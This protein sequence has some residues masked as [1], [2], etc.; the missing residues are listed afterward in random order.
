MVKCCVF[1]E[2]WTELL[3]NIYM[4][5]GIKGLISWLVYRLCYLTVFYQLFG[6]LKHQ[7]HSVMYKLCNTV[8]T[9]PLGDQEHFHA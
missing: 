4:S 8:A 2:V 9:A 5:F 1:F 6:L 3:N 7:E